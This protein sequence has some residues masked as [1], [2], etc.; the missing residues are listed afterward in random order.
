[1]KEG[2]LSIAALLILLLSTITETYAQIAPQP[3]TK[4][5]DVRVGGQLTIDL[6]LGSIYIKN[7]CW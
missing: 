7:Q 2:L 1:M 4:T 3:V 6:D 5:F